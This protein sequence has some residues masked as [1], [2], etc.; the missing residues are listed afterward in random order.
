MEVVVLSYRNLSGVVFVVGSVLV[1]GVFVV[2]A[3]AGAV[4]WCH[5]CRTYVSSD[6][7]LCPV[8][9]SYLSRSPTK[10]YNYSKVVNRFSGFLETNDKHSLYLQIPTYRRGF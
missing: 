10:E 9:G 3:S 5:S 4:G 6:D 7:G 2:E 8:C 1:G